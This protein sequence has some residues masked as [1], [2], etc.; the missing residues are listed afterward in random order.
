V[1]VDDD[2]T[3]ERIEAARVVAA[4]LTHFHG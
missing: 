2:L 1:G 3:D 4:L